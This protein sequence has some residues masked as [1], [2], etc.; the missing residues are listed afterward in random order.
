MKKFIYVGGVELKIENKCDGGEMCFVNRAFLLIFLLLIWF[1]GWGGHRSSCRINDSDLE[2]LNT[3]FS[4]I[5]LNP[6]NSNIVLP[7]SYTDY[8]IPEIGDNVVASK[9]KIGKALNICPPVALIDNI[10]D[11]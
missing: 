6:E 7:V 10:N 1:S 8:Y 3:N 2:Y 5:M 9:C 4:C 11:D